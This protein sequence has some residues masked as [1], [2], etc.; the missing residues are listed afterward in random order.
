MP[1]LIDISLGP[2]HRPHRL[3]CFCH[4]HPRLHRLPL[5]PYIPNP[6][7]PKSLLP[8]PR[9]QPCLFCRYHPRRL[10]HLPTYILSMD[11]NDRRNGALR[12]SEI[13]R[14]LH[15][16]IQSS[17]RCYGR[18]AAYA[19][20][21]GAEDGSGPENHVDWHV[22]HGCDVCSFHSQ[23]SQLCSHHSALRAYADHIDSTASALSLFTASTQQR[24]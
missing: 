15:W 7:I 14:P 8:D 22:W 5:H 11:S 19:S 1:T 16:D 10:P 20:P 9:N 3:G 12:I 21:L 18:S 4:I 23:A 6:L 2:I 24:P 13:S 17:P